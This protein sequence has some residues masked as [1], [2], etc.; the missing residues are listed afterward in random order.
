MLGDAPSGFSERR[1][2]FAAACVCG[3]HSCDGRTLDR[4]RRKVK[5]G[6]PSGH[7]TEVRFSYSMSSST[8]AGYR[9]H[10]PDQSTSCHFTYNVLDE[11]RRAIPRA[12]A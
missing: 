8:T 9:W 7:V 2:G 12:A 3:D 6:K 5:A 11:K 4:S 10:Q 1:Q